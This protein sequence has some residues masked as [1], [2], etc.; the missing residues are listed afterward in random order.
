[1]FII[2]GD[3]TFFPSLY[4]STGVPELTAGAIAPPKFGSSVMIAPLI[5]FD[6]LN[7]CKHHQFSKP[8]APPEFHLPHYEILQL[9]F[10]QS[11]NSGIKRRLGR[12]VKE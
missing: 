5:L 7:I 11:S 9:Q 3:T 12:S 8:S 4:I 2:K 10:Y 1:M 6:Q